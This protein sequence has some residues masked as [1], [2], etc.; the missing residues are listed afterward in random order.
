MLYAKWFAALKAKWPHLLWVNNL[1][2]TLEPSLINISNGRMFE[3]GDGATLTDL[4][5]GLW[6]G[7]P[8]HILASSVV[9]DDV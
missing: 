6:S 3:G 8:R 1:V 4:L 9:L 5:A 7:I 2:D